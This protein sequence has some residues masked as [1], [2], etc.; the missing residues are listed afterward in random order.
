LVLKVLQDNLDL[1]VNLDHLVLKDSP[2]LKDPLELQEL[3]DR[4]VQLGLREIAELLDL[5]DRQELLVVL[6]Q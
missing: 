5:Q 4:V 3:L 2:V 1:W 6:A